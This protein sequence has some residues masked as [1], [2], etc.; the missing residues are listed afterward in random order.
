ME[1]YTKIGL[2]LL[3]LGGILGIISNIAFSLAGNLAITLSVLSGIGGLCSFIGIILLIVGRKEFGEKHRKF[4]V[5][6]L[7]LFIL[8]III[9]VIII[10]AVTFSYVSQG[11]SGGVDVSFMQN[12][13]F[14]IP[15]AAILGGL[16]Y[17]LLLYNLE[18]DI[19]RRILFVAFVV[20]VITSII[21][22][23][24]IGPAFEETIGSIDFETASQQDISEVTTEFSQKISTSGIYGLAN[25]VL[26]LIALIIPYKRI[27]SGELIPISTSTKSVEPDRICPNCG[28]A[29][30]FD[31]EIC[32][33]CSK[34]FEDYF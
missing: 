13:F 3:I 33:Y 11:I 4:V 32:P 31:A 14:I 18:N 30:P 34:K 8:S 29:I 10:A 15:F 1:S 25:G 24:N 20:A 6:A 21:I 16:A 7:I 23:L 9:P 22:S 5:Y 27:T 28:K 19:G 2:L 26:M 12:I 17:V